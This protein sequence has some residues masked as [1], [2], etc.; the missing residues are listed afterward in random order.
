MLSNWQ[1]IGPPSAIGILIFMCAWFKSLQH[2]LL[3]RHP[4]GW[5]WVNRF[6]GYPLLAVWAPYSIY[7]DTQ[8][9]HHCN[10]NLTFLGLDPES[11]FVLQE[12]RKYL[13]RGRR[14]VLTLRNS[15][16]DRLGVGA[17]LSCFA[18]RVNG[19]KVQ[20]VRFTA[21]LQ[22]LLDRATLT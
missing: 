21:I 10:E 2:E 19:A 6:V 3:H 4:S 17:L 8:I 16:F 1:R 7:R 13:G 20:G 14:A 5:R 15:T 9:T 22:L 18:A 11:Y 12:K